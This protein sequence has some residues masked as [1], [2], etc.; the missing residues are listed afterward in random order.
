VNS[1]SYLPVN[2]EGENIYLNWIIRSFGGA[3]ILLSHK[4]LHQRIISSASIIQKSRTRN[5]QISCATT[6]S[7]QTGD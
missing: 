5:S 6:N 3:T 7:E 1:A 2:E 4:Y